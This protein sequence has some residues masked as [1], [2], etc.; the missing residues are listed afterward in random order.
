MIL[1]GNVPFPRWQRR[2][3]R[4]IL[5]EPGGGRAS[6]RLEQAELEA[7]AAV[8]APLKGALA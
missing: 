1:Q 8:S 2:R 5:S 3:E 4:L 7:L 6:E